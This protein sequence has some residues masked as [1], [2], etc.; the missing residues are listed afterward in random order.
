M[1]LRTLSAITLATAV[2][3]GCGEH[4]EQPREAPDRNEDTLE[5]ARTIDRFFFE[6][7]RQAQREKIRRRLDN[8]APVGTVYVD[9]P[10]QTTVNGCESDGDRLRCNWTKSPDEI[11]SRAEWEPAHYWPGEC[12]VA[13]SVGYTGYACRDAQQKWTAGATEELRQYGKIYKLGIRK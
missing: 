7:A 5:M 9:V 11:W 2:G 4:N 10:N 3:F 6:P 12:Y 8:I 13:P 1:N